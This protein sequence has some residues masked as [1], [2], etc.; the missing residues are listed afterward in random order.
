MRHIV[1]NERT[2]KFLPSGG[3]TPNELSACR[4]VDIRLAWTATRF[5]PTPFIT[6]WKT[7]MPLNLLTAL[8]RMTPPPLDITIAISTGTQPSR[9]TFNVCSLARATR[10]LRGTTITT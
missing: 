3:K 8:S 7:A 6:G 2:A 4:N 9:S 10:T 1:S 5:P